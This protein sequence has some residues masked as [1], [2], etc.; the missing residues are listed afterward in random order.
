MTDPARELPEDTE[1]NEKPEPEDEVHLSFIDHLDELRKRLIRCILGIT[2]GAIVAGVFSENIFRAIMSPVLASLPQGQQQLHYTSYLEPFF[3]YLKVAIYGGIFLSAPWVL[4]QVWQ[5]VAPG[6]YKKEKRVV[7]PF[8]AAGTLCF[9]AGAAACYFFVMPYA[10]PALAAIAGPD[11]SP[12]LT[13]KEQLSL[14]LAMLLGFGIIFELPVIIGFLALIGVVTADWLA[15]Y[16][17]YAA[18]INVALAAVIT[19]T[20]DPL[21]LAL[22]AVPMIVFY[23]IGIILARVLGKKRTPAADA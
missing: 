15:K 6:L 4:Y 11:M 18:V 5:F 2:A 14:V 10:F 19:P 20:G 12:I 8:I 3:V 13:M 9:Y 1:P 22:M 17:R 7:V 16:R 21:N 23:E